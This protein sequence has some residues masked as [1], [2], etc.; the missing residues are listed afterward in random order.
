MSSNEVEIL[1]KHI[2]KSART[3]GVTMS[4]NSLVQKVFTAV[5]ALLIERAKDAVSRSMR[6]FNDNFNRH[7]SNKDGLL[8]Y[9]ELEN[10]F[11]ES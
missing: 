11:L 9:P 8:E 4:M 2:T 1:F 6:S 10:L 7:D 3:I 5:D